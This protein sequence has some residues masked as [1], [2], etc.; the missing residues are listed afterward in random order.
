MEEYQPTIT[1]RAFLYRIYKRGT[2]GTLVRAL[3]RCLDI[4]QP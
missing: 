2:I 3:L 1:R 4:A